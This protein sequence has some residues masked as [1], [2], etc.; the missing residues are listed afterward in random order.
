MK[1]II[2][3]LFIASILLT[4]CATNTPA[5]TQESAAT[6]R[7]TKPPKAE[8]TSTATTN[9][10]VKESA[11]KG[12]EIMVWNPWYGV[13]AGLFDSLVKDFNKNNEWG[14]KVGAESQGNFANLYDNVSASLPTAKKPDLVIALPEHALKWDADG[15]TTDLAP[16][17]EDPHGLKRHPGRVLGSRPC[18]RKTRRHSRAAQ[19]AFF[20]LE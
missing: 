10:K 16:Y 14:I 6:P 7:A 13:E 15:V 12:L 11:L 2:S 8:A 18:R 20:A 1:K 17:V 4:S 5:A 19:R 9:F 3:L